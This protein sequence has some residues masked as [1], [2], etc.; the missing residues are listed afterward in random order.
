M[1]S[2][3]VISLGGSIVVPDNPDTGFIAGFRDL[4]MERID[5]GMRFIIIVGGGRTS[6]R[7]VEAAGT[8]DAAVSDEDKDWIGIHATRL[9]AH[10]LRTVFRTVA[11]PR[12]NDNPHNH[13]EFADFSE[14]VLVASGWR[15]G[16]STDFC[17]VVLGRHLGASTVVNLSN[18]D[19]VYDKDPRAHD[20][21][22]RHETLSWDAYRDIV[23]GAWTPG[24]HAPFD[25]VASR[26]AAEHD[27]T[28]AIMNGTDL[29]NVGAYLDGSTWR[30][31]TLHP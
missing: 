20:D 5:R 11:H 8:V 17:A 6:R 23:G 22:L 19:Y 4:V 9:N 14:P 26:F 7:Y 2:P 13:E 15:P 3:V 1:Q 30:G 31:T 21:A 29:A 25:P 12:I 28:V 18:I 16:S 27:M 24:M 10:L